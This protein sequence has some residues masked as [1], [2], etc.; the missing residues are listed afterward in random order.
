MTTN[1]KICDFWGLIMI[2]KGPLDSVREAING[3][4]PLP[5]GNYYAAR[6][7]YDYM[8]S[9]EK[10]TKRIY[11]QIGNFE[12][13]NH[14]SPHWTIPSKH[15]IQEYLERLVNDGTAE[16]VIV[17]IKYKTDK[18]DDYIVGYRSKVK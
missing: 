12:K 3:I 2:R 18:A 16:S 1:I 17:T 5:H 4:N 10:R 8:I 9:E 11:Y 6:S 13:S 15:E 14:W 7:L